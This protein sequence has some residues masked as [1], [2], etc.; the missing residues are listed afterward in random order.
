MFAQAVS[1]PVISSTVPSGERHR[2]Q[3]VQLPRLRC[4]GFRP[5]CHNRMLAAERR[6]ATLLCPLRVQLR[7]GPPQGRR[8]PPVAGSLSCHRSE[9]AADA[10]RC[11]PSAR[12]RP[13]DGAYKLNLICTAFPSVAFIAWHIAWHIACCHITPFL[14]C[15]GGAILPVC[16]IAGC[17]ITPFCSI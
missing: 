16:Y 10:L 17:H 7:A 14:V 15:S 3:A 9:S 4:N 11:L 6:E 1:N 5:S 2:V 13:Y 8:R 12:H